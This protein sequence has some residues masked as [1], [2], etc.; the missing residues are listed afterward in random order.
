M[1]KINSK[2]DFSASRNVSKP[3]NLQQKFK[4]KSYELLLQA[5]LLITG[6]SAPI[7]RKD[8]Y[9]KNSIPH[10]IYCVFLV[11]AIASATVVTLYGR[12]KYAIKCIAFTVK[13]NEIIFQVLLSTTL[14][15]TI[16][17]MTFR[18]PNLLNELV[19]KLKYIDN[20]L[21]TAKIFKV[22]TLHL[23]VRFIIFHI[24]FGFVCVGYMYLEIKLLKFPEWLYFPFRLY[25]AYLLMMLMFQLI[26]Y[27]D[28]IYLR[29]SILNERLLETFEH[30]SINDFYS[31]RVQKLINELY[32]KG[33][34][35]ISS[36]YLSMKEVRILHCM[37]SDAFEK[38]NNFFGIIMFMILLNIIVVVTLLF[39]KLFIYATGIH[40]TTMKKAED[41]KYLIPSLCIVTTLVIVVSISI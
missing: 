33:F 23:F 29:F 20:Q 6:L 21:G 38:T 19:R 41:Y 4:S 27:I 2:R 34:K 28:D 11:V 24:G 26:A 17:N 5:V 15:L 7:N 3:A 10:K 32:P 1:V 22:G 35:T 16:L 8:S 37:I 18:G 40:E 12:I 31:H 13:L 39:N 30:W 9:F 14:C 36:R 25:T